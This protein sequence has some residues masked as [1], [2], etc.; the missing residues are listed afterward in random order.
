MHLNRRIKIQLVIFALIALVAATIMALGY[1]KLPAMFGIGRY[2]VTV[3]LSRSGGLYPAANVTYRGTQVGKVESVDLTGTA[4]IEAV[5]SLN[6]GIDIPSNLKA[7][8]HSASAIGEQ[9]VALLPRDA[10]SPPLKDGNVIALADTSVP[11]DI[12]TLLDDTNSGLLAIPH[13]SLQTTIDESYTAFGGL[14]PEL[15]RLV[16][17]AT[18]L[19]IDARANLDSLTTLIDQSAPVLDTQTQ[20]ADSIKAWASHLATITGQ[21]R[22]ND[23]AFAGLIDNGGPAADEARQ[24]VERLEPTLPVILANLVSVGKVAVTYQ[25]AIEQLLVL[26]PQGIANGQAAVVPNLN[27]K[28]PYAGAYLDFDLNLNLPPPCLTGYLPPQQRRVPSMT[29]APERPAGDLYCRTPQDG[30]FNV[31][32]AKNLPCLTVPGKRAP[33]VKMCE[34]N[35]NYVPLNDGFYWKGDP[36]ATLTGQDIPQLPPGTPPRGTPPAAAPPAGPPPLAVAQYDPATG[37]YVGPDGHIYTQSD[38]TE[39]TPKVNTWQGMLLPPTHN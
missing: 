10:T 37:S 36:N 30:P 28:Q 11:P 34:S 38:V 9:Y 4:N 12:D 1:I 23:T 16:K 24:L 13:D 15:S 26:I 25:P 7:E 29:D 3:E 2:T 35:E 19:G 39:K 27:T 8:V 32:G 6:T 21:L 33:T 14:G 17:G 31:R 18:T 20:T 5:L 22:N